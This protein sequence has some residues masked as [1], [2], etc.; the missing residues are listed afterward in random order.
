LQ[1]GAGFLE[2][3]GF[4]KNDDAKASCRKRKGGRQSSDP[5][6]SDEDGA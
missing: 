2:A 1:A 6:T 5:G 3:L 4:F